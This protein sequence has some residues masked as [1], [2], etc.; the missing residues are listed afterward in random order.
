M[1]ERHLSDEELILLH[2]GEA[3]DPTAAEAHLRECPAC[4]ESQDQLVRTLRLVPADEPPARDAGYGSRVWARVRPR[5]ESAT[6]KPTR[7]LLPSQLVSWGA[8]AASLAFAFW[9]GRQFPGGDT[10]GP[11]VRERILLVALGEH[12]ERSRMVLAEVTNAQ[13]PAQVSKDRRWAESLVAENRLYRQAAVRSGDTAAASLL[14]ELERVLAE[15]A[16]GP[17]ELSHRQLEELRARIE[18]R[19]LVFKVKVV[20]GQLRAKT[21]RAAPDRKETSS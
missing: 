7:R 9:L 17:D 14:D 16:N 2:Y 3:D 10:A 8:L 4:A 19:G 13:D 20:E 15:V 1:S 12:L 21:R 6:G 11:V 5:L 18:E